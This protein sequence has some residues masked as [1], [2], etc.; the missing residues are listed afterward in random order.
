LLQA[1]PFSHGT[2]AKV[3]VNVQVIPGGWSGGI[4]QFLMGV[5]CAL[6]RLTAGGEQYSL[7]TSPEKP[8]LSGA[9]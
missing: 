1:I 9:I 5:V 2:S 6:G 7:I 4:G 3:L 8:E